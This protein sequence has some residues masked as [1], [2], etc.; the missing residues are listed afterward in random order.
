MIDTLV[1]A[2][3][4]GKTENPGATH[5]TFIALGVVIGV[6]LIA[7][8]LRR[9]LG[10]GGS[11]MGGGSSG[12]NR[13]AFRKAARAAGLS[14]DESRF[15]EDYGKVLGVTSPEFV[16]KNQ[17]RLDAFFKDSYKSIEK[18]SENEAEADERKAVL[19]QIRERLSQG[20]SAV[21]QVTSTRQL[22]KNMPLSLLVKGEE[23][24]PST[25]LAVEPGGIAAEPP[26]DPYGETI[27]LKRG[28]K[29]VCYFYGKGRQGYQF[30]TRVTGWELVGAREVMVISHSESVKALPAR[31]HERKELRTPC[32][33]YRVAVATETVHGK[34]RQKAKVEKIP[35]SGMISDI[36]AGGVGIQTANPLQAGEFV[37]IEFDTG[38]GVQS[39]FGKVV[40]MNR[41]RTSGGIMHI[42][43]VKIVRRSLNAILSYVYGYSE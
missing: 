5:G 22:G 3:I 35:Y 41:L 6:L 26:H 40:R 13:G 30:D 23:S 4:L 36:S 2:Q 1:L 19:F 14:P 11:L 12:F 32:T 16:F 25:I 42:Q 31:R 8:I 28:T 20:R 39:G 7:A 38:N 33:F 10:G 24:Y 18:Y 27:R 21:V 43:F 37:K 17:S 9:V 15:L 34:P 29:L